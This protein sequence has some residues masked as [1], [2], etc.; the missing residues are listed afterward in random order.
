MQWPF[1]NWGATAVLTG[2]DH[3]Y[4]RLLINNFPYFVNGSGGLPLRTVNAPIE[5]SKVFN[6]RDNGAMLVEADLSNISFKFFNRA[7]VLIDSYTVNANAPVANLIDLPKFFVLQHYQD[8]L[9][10]E[11]EQAGLDYW[12]GQMTK[13]GD[14]PACLNSRRVGVSAAF[15]VEQEFQQTGYVVY[16]MY[17]AAFGTL[18]VPNQTRANILHTQFANDRGLIVGGDQLAL[19]TVGF[20]NGFVQ[21]EQ[22][23]TAYPDSMSD[24]DFVNKLYDTAGLSPFTSERASAIQALTNR[25]KTRAQVLLDLIET[26]AFKSREYNPAFVLMQYF[27]Y[28]K[29]DPDQGGYDFWLGKVTNNYR[30]MVCAFITSREYQL[31]FGTVVTRNDS[32]CSNAGL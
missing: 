11:P 21:R 32:I 3:H 26:P 13:C 12:T 20:A 23:K 6:D 14:D 19:S 24:A 10:R 16:R 15:F 7:G 9:G 18:P 8:F 17:R 22:F 28:L 27:G 4:E 1:Q 2:H 30:E 29:R 31:R 25:A 5:G